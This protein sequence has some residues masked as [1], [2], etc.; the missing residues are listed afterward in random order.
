MTETFD[1]LRAQLI[2][3]L[4]HAQGVA[5]HPPEF[6]DDDDDDDTDEKPEQRSP[7][8]NVFEPQT[9]MVINYKRPLSPIMEESE[10]ETCKTFVMNETKNLD[11]TSTGCVETGEAIMGV[12][13]TLMASNDTLFNFEDTFG[14]D[15]FSPRT[16]SQNDIVKDGKLADS[17]GPSTPTPRSFKPM[18]FEVNDVSANDLL[19]PD[20]QKTLSEDICTE[21]LSSDAVDT[22][23]T[24]NTLEEKTCISVHIREDEKI[25]EISEPDWGSSG[26][27]DLNSLN[28]VPS[29]GVM[30]N[31]EDDEQ[32]ECNDFENDDSSSTV[33]IPKNDENVEQNDPPSAQHRSFLPVHQQNGD[34][35]SYKDKTSNFLL[36][37]IKYSAGHYQK[38]SE[39]RPLIYDNVK[40]NTD[41]NSKHYDQTEATTNKGDEN[42]MFAK[43]LTESGIFEGDLLNETDVIMQN[44]TFV[45]SDH[46]FFLFGV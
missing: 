17:S 10:D 13:K 38:S 41:P 5:E 11:S 4:P 29:M 42:N 27:F 34:D 32:S 1:A 8:E 43:N 46:T 20:Q 33:N 6:S 3:M 30:E 45:S 40:E 12:T 31:G 15:V 7:C 35:E 28:D 18:E 14:D 2:I 26:Q 44:S 25:S 37:E 39:I 22:T 23:F 9:E 16:N 36:N 19:S 21:H 24:T